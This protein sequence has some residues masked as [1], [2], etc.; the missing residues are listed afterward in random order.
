MFSCVESHN[1]KH[2]TGFLT[3]QTKTESVV[4][5]VLL[6]ADID[7]TSSP[8]DDYYSTICSVNSDYLNPLTMINLFTF[9]QPLLNKPNHHQLTTIHTTRHKSGTLQTR[10]M[11]QSR[12]N[13]IPII[14]LFESINIHTQHGSHFQFGTDDIGTNRLGAKGAG[15]EVGLTEGGGSSAV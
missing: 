5:Y 7:A 4:K 6:K 9:A 10:V 15:G 14:I 13:R 2:H 1:L 11:P 3:L 8:C 12:Q